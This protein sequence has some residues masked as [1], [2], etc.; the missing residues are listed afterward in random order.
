MRYPKKRIAKV[1]KKKIMIVDDEEDVVK[2][3]VAALGTKDFDIA[4]AYSGEECLE[5]VE[6]KK[7]NLILLDIILPGI[8]GLEVLKKLKS[9]VQTKTITT[10]LISASAHKK[11]MERG[12]SAGADAYIVKPFDPLELKRKVREILKKSS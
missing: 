10:I 3:M 5:K 2:L 11:Q 6:R 4:T 9:D 1:N 12:L 8:D 7:P